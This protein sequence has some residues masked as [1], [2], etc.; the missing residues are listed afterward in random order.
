MI[1]ISSSVIFGFYDSLF[2]MIV[3]KIKT[4]LCFQWRQL[5]KGINGDLEWK[6]GKNPVLAF[7]F[8]VLF[9]RETKKQISGVKNN[10]ILLEPQLSILSQI[11]P[12]IIH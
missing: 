8:L 5:S 7:F 10:Y 9:G 12:G 3:C 11:P 2:F 4:F 6:A 1:P